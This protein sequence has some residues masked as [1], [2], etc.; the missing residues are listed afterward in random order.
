MNSP[1]RAR[2]VR[3]AAVAFAIASLTLF[4]AAIAAA[5]TTGRIGGRV[6]ATDTGEPLGFANLRL[7]PADTTM[8]RLGGMTNADGT[9]LIEA[10]AGRYTLEVGAISYAKRRVAGLVIRAGE[11]LP[12][13]AALEPEAILQKEIVVEAKAK[14]NTEASLLAARRKSASLGDAVSAEQVRRTP[15]KDAAEVLRRV[16]G[17]SVADGKYVFVRGL[18]ERYSSTDV[19]GVRIASPEQNKRVVPL[20]LLPANLLDHIT[21]QK[22][23]TTDRPGEFGGGDVQ[24]RTKD[25][26]GHRTWSVS[27]S[28]GYAEGVTF[29]N[30]RT[31]RSTRADVFG[32]GSAFRDVPDAVAG[33]RLPVFFPTPQVRGQ[34]GAAARAFDGIW[35]A[36]NDRAAP[37][38]N[39]ALTYGDEWKLFGRPLGLIQ[40]WSLARS[41]D[42]QE[43]SQRY[44]LSGDTLY[45]YRQTRWTENVQLGGLAGLSYRLSPRHS[46]H[47][48][49]LYSNS[50]EDEV[51]VYEGA[52]H[53][54]SEAITNT[55]LQRR[56][57]RFLYVQRTVLSGSL[58]GRHE[59]ARLFG[60]SV[61]WKLARSQA[62]RQQ[63]DRREISWNRYYWF[64]GD[65][66]HWV[67]NGIG[68]RDYGDL[69]DDGDGVTLTTS[70]PFR[71]AGLG[72]GRITL[73]YDRQ[74]KK[75]D[76]FYRRFSIF[77]SPNVELEQDPDSVFS[78]NT[79]DGSPATGY[80]QDVTY[81][82]PVVGLDNY[83]ADQTTTAG[84]VSADVPFGPRVRANLGVRIEKGDQDVRSFAL[85]A[86]GTVLQRGRLENTD[87]L[88]AVNLTVSVTDAINAR[89]AASRTISRPDL[90]ELS[91]TPFLEYI[92]GM[93]V[94]GNPDLK[95]A[96][97]ENYDLRIEAFPGL[98]EVL[99]VGVFYKKLHDPIEQ[100]IRGGTPLLLQPRNSAGG[101]NQGLELEARVGLGRFAPAL[102][103]FSLNSNASFISSKVTLPPAISKLG[104][105]EH[106]LQGQAD[107][108]VNAGL[109]Y[110]GPA[111]LDVAVMVNAVGKRLRTL[112]VFPF[113]DVYAQPATTL[114]ASAGVTVFHSWRVRLAAKNLT[115]PKQQLLQGAKEVSG[116]RTGRSYSVGVS[117]GS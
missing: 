85:F 77:A 74:S 40:S 47:L 88:P 50:A 10:P 32:F 96:R 86:P 95:R 34:L 97:L 76:N 31:Y 52:D 57:Q 7:L 90:N 59:F 94:M 11:L 25:F 19:D 23:Y 28:Q 116:Y 78:P 102:R 43:E 71:L 67:L 6:V 101:R 82:N 103:G 51:R 15:D 79:F 44:F 41:F 5:Q 18:G 62:R 72:K 109:A 3:R 49:G 21:V 83:E 38:S 89:M 75:R 115:D 117:F 81:N 84:F 22:T 66:A 107:Y 55:W 4:G 80:V 113:P 9:F 108:L 73:G 48:R 17:L 100:T 27:L 58:E 105:E 14:T 36:T 91:P 39:Y 112:A 56:D 92:G 65:T 8:R 61:D 12:F 106:P 54:T 35:S 69:H 114:D 30:R 87:V 63:P 20:D 110:G 111:G 13:D 93:M 53:N 42:T 16:T 70:A 46:L 104:T 64:E 98:S 68:N 33:A 45:D 2:A 37:N 24:V 1:L 99:A 60:A 29:Q 26:P